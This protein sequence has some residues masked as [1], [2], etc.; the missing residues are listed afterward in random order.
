MSKASNWREKLIQR[1]QGVRMAH[2]LMQIAKDGS[3][4]RVVERLIRKQ[5][6]GSLGRPDGEDDMGD[7]QVVAGD[8]TVEQPRPRT[9]KL[10]SAILGAAVLAAGA[11]LGAGIPLGWELLQPTPPPVAPA[12]SEDRD[13]LFELDLG[14]GDENQSEGQESLSQGS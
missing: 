2:D 14:S 12:K 11:G 1:R 9:S 6:D 4:Q 7:I 3:R 5:Q 10:A 8:L 13:T